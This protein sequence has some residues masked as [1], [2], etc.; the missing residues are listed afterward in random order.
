MDG[1]NEGMAQIY[2]SFSSQSYQGSGTTTDVHVY[3]NTTDLYDGAI[4]RFA[5]GGSHAAFGTSPVLGPAPAVSACL[6]ETP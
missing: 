5:G 3:H 4:S 6:P 1:P 2:A